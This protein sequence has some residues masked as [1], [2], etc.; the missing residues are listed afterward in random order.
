MSRSMHIA[1]TGKK[2]GQWVTCS[3]ETNCRNGGTHTSAAA[4]QSAKKWA[5]VNK[6]ENL[7]QEHYIDYLKSRLSKSDTETST[8]Q[9][10]S[11]IVAKTDHWKKETRDERSARIARENNDDGKVIFEKDFVIK[12]RLRWKAFLDTAISMD[13]HIDFDTI[14]D[15]GKFFAEGGRGFSF[16]KEQIRVPKE[17]VEEF[18]VRTNYYIE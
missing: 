13:V 2:A 7:T 12:S 4:L 18:K 14:G 5:G 9:K 10:D 1:K 8:P 6:L 17:K 16:K 3:A 11:T 15:A